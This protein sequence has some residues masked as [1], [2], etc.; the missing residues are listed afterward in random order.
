LKK[1]KKKKKKMKTLSLL[2]AGLFAAT[3]LSGCEQTSK[4][5]ACEPPKD[6]GV[7]SLGLATPLP[8][9]FDASRLDTRAIA[10]QYTRGVPVIAAL[11]GGRYTEV[12][13]YFDDVARRPTFQDQYLGI[14]TVEHLLH[15][16]GLYLLP[17]AQAWVASVPESRAAKLTLGLAYSSAAAK[18][19]GGGYASDTT[20]GQMATYR[21]RLSFAT[22][23]LEALAADNDAAGMTARNALMHSYFMSG[24]AEEGWAIREAL[25]G[26]MPLLISNYIGALDHAHPKWSGGR[27]VERGAQVL[28][29]AEKNGLDPQQLKLLEQI[30]ESHRNDIEKNENPQAWR[31]YWE[32]RVAAAPTPFNLRHLVYKESSVQ[33]WSVVVTLAQKIIDLSPD[34]SEALYQK[35][36]ALQ[37]LGKND[38][39]FSAMVAASTAGSDGAMGQIVYSY[40]KGT[41]GRKPRDFDTM[42]EYCKFG[43]ALGMPAAANCMASSFTDGFGGA[44]RDDKQAVAWHLQAARG[45][46]MN[47]MHDLAVLLP[48]FV[49]GSDGQMAAAYW[50]RKAADAK[51]VYALKKVG[52][53]PTPDLAL[54]CRLANKP[55]EFA[56]ILIK[57]Y[58]FF[59]TL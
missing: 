9:P 25:I 49:P 36:Y 2:V 53:E 56:D 27:S 40:V 14:A 59:H 6:W 48:R 52:D 19:H 24:R 26:K 28:A 33:N 5:L 30:V 16:R 7:E 22:P 58:Q 4:F 3:L 34:D 31:P 38:E 39:A 10:P 35:A 11:A 20:V 17:M 21:Q 41:L 42:Y 45:D 29:L 8:L 15:A 12:Q 32:A 57:A 47:S 18:A 54:G 44:K 46:E 55:T 23:L 13:R 1:K 43:A 37:Q 50:M 51:H